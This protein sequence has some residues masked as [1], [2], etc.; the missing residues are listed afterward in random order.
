MQK[1][2]ENTLLPWAPAHKCWTLGRATRSPQRRAIR[3]LIPP[4]VHQLPRAASPQIWRLLPRDGPHP[5]PGLCRLR[6][7]WVVQSVER[8]TSA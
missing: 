6:S 3:G 8:L 4:R 2:I 7:D 1:N 5:G